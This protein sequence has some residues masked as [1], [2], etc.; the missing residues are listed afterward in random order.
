MAALI[1]I[2]AWRGREGADGSE[3]SSSRRRSGITALERHACCCCVQDRPIF[4]ASWRPP[5]PA[6]IAPR[7]DQVEAPALQKAAKPE[8]P[9]LALIGAV[10]G[11]SDAIAVFVDRTNQK[12][13]RLRLGETHS[14]RVLSS[15]LPREATLMKGD[16]VEVLVLQRR[17]APARAPGVP[18]VA[19]P[20]VPAGGGVDVS[21]APLTPLD[22]EGRRVGR[23]PGLKPAELRS[24]RRGI[25]RCR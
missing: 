22:A 15:V 6:M 4:L 23:S 11:E 1:L 13:V 18:V 21:Y 14:G 9:P 10:V 19:A 8:R 2:G 5:Q 20:P 12:F 3:I 17:D 7:V 24:P 25:W 16:R